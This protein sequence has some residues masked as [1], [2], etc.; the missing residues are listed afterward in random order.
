MQRFY[1]KDGKV[2]QEQYDKCYYYEKN[3]INKKGYYIDTTDKMTKDEFVSLYLDWLIERIKKI[4]EK[5]K[6]LKCENYLYRKEYMEL[7]CRNLQGE[8][9]K[10]IY[11]DECDT[12]KR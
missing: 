3:V 1:V 10:Y 5:I 6:K 7:S 8:N 9:F 2:Y 12:Y 4:D 11:L